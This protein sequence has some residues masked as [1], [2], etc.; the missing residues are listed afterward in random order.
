MFHWFKKHTITGEEI[1]DN[2]PIEITLRQ[3]PFT[4]A[5]RIQMLTKSEDLKQALKK[6]RMDTFEEADDFEID[7]VDE[8]GAEEEAFIAG[9]PLDHIRTRLDEQK[10]FM[11]EEMPKERL[12]GA[13]ARLSAKPKAQ[14]AADAETKVEAKS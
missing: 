14:P 12:E 8:F 13:K 2:T 1:P 7:D 10:A 9:V 5:E 11:T 3:K 4:L 6:N